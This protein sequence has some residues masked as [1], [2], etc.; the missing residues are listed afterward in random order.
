MVVLLVFGGIEQRYR[1]IFPMFCDRCEKCRLPF[2]FGMIAA[3]ELGPSS[4]IVVEPLSKHGG[5][6]EIGQPEVKL[7]I[8]LGKPP[9]PQPINQQPETIGL[10]SRFIDTLGQDLTHSH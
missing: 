2:Q 3:A 8:R 1:A 10:G 4:G 7:R 9:W 5:W 6:P